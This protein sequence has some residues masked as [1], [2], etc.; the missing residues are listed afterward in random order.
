MPA[1]L[2][3]PFL[4]CTGAMDPQAIAAKVSSSH[5]VVPTSL[6][7]TRHA[8]PSAVDALQTAS[9]RWALGSVFSVNHVGPLPCWNVGLQSH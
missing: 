3:P 8:S 6:P 2:R 7:S 5:D 4:L 9:A 1:E